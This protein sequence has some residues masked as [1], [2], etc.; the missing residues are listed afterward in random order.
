MLNLFAGV[1][2]QK[3]GFLTVGGDLLAFAGGTQLVS[4]GLV[5]DVEP[6]SGSR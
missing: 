2:F 3:F 6:A 5:T 4:G 1:F